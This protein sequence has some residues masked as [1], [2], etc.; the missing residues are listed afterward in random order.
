MMKSWSWGAVLG[1]AGNYLRYGVVRGFGLALFG[2]ALAPAVQA[3]TDFAALFPPPAPR[4]DQTPLPKEVLDDQSF[5][6]VGEEHHKLIDQARN[7]AALG[8]DLFGDQTNLQTGSTEF[9]H[10]DI[11]LPGNNGLS[12]RLQRRFTAASK[13]GLTQVRQAAFADWE[14]EV[15]YLSGE[16]ATENGWQVQTEGS[17]ITKQRCSATEPFRALPPWVDAPGNPPYSF[18]PFE[19]WHGYHLHLP[20][21]GGGE[22]LWL[23][24]T[25]TTQKPTDGPSYYWATNGNW[26]FSC[27][28]GPIGVGEIFIGRSPDGLRYTFGHLVNRQASRLSANGSTAKLFRTEVRLV[29][30]RVEDRFGNWVAY[31]WS[32]SQL[33][34]IT[35]SDGR[36]I[37][38]TYNP[39]TGYVTT[40]SDGTRTWSYAY[41]G[42]GQIIGGSRTTAPSLSRVIRPDNSAWA[43]NFASLAQANVASERNTANCFGSGEPVSP[44]FTGSLTHPSGA[45]GTFTFGPVQ[46]GRTRVPRNCVNEDPL[47]NVGDDYSWFTLTFDVLALKTKRIAGGVLPTQQWDYSYASNFCFA[48]GDGACTASTPDFSTTTVV[49]LGAGVDRYR[50]GNVYQGNDGKLL[51]VEH[52]S[53]VTVN[54]TLQGV[55]GSEESQYQLDGSSQVYPSPIGVSPQPRGDAFT[56]E[57]FL[58]LRQ[59]TISQDGASFVWQAQGFDRYAQPTQVQRSSSLGFEKTE[60]TTYRNDTNLWLIGQTE[61]LQDAE[62]GLVEQF[63]QFFANGQ[64]STSFAF[65]DLQSSFQ[66]HPDG[67]VR[68]ITDGR[69]NATTLS[70]YF[71]GV[72]QIVQYADGA[73]QSA[74]V[75]PIGNISQITDAMGFSSNFGYDAMGR[76]NRIDYPTGDSTAWNATTRSFAPVASIEF[77]I[78]AGHWKLIEQT[79]SGRTSTFYDAFWRPVLTLTEDS[80]DP[81]TR[82]YVVN[83][84]DAKGRLAFTSYPVASLATINDSLLGTSTQYDLL[85]RPTELRQDSELG[86]LLTRSAYLPGFQT[87]VTDPRGQVTTTDFQAFDTPSTETPMRIVLPDG[88]TTTFTRDDFG[89]PL[90]VTRS[91][92]GG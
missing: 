77:G 49:Q 21:G 70:D 17:A 44:D 60:L 26:F 39:T 55:I 5:A 7:L 29:A 64:V 74:I 25:N 4:V 52:G 19:Y 79:G 58:P 16:F 45:T 71:R 54:G 47:G 42:T 40:A 90:S 1:V 66:Y 24:P 8:P 20:G 62:T 89:K 36:S 33:A 15:P 10:T 63:N 27:A 31:N 41:T 48:S 38:F 72:P 13:R 73:S 3:E 65:G 76:L 81:A 32:G 18:R 43:I 56:A 53:S 35:A 83:R 28:N 2:A 87:Q 57:N 6:F 78:P 23:S 82:S 22:L 12:V 68:S 85:G 88:S 75:S 30:T 37:T 61:S 92:N 84:Y 86:P 46:H 9:I 34:S 67:S 69:G 50:F 91:S 80:S 51:K 59:K 11:D 14:L